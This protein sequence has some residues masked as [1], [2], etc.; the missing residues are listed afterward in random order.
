MKLNKAQMHPRP[1]YETLVKDKILEPKDKIAL[2]DRAATIIR[3]TQQLS[4]YDDA[5]FLDLEKDNG[6]IAKEQAQ[7]NTISAA[8]GIDVGGSIAQTRA[9][10]PGPHQGHTFAPPPPV[11]QP[12]TQGPP[13]TH[14]TLPTPRG[15]P[16]T[17][18]PTSQAATTPIPQQFDIGIDDDMN[19][20]QRETDKIFEEVTR[21]NIRKGKS[22]D[23]QIAR[24]LGPD[25]ETAD[26]SYVAR[27]AAEGNKGR[28][29][30]PRGDATKEIEVQTVKP[31]QKTKP[32]LRE[33]M[34]KLQ[35]GRSAHRKD[36]TIGL[37]PPTGLQ[38]PPVGMEP[39]K[40]KAESRAEA[41]KR[42]PV[43]VPRGDKA[44]KMDSAPIASKL[45]STRAAS[46]RPARSRSRKD[47]QPGPA[48]SSS[49]AAPAT[50]KAKSRSRSIRTKP[51]PRAASEPAAA[52][53]TPKAK[54]RSRSRGDVRKEKE[55][56]LLAITVPTSRGKKGERSPP[57]PEDKRTRVRSKT[58]DA[59]T[60]RRQAAA[61]AANA[62]P[63]APV[64]KDKPKVP[65]V[66]QKPDPAPAKGPTLR[67]KGVELDTNNDEAYWA[68]QG[69]G[70]IHDQL[71]LRGYRAPMKTKFKR[72]KKADLAKLIITVPLPP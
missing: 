45:E 71:A 59:K 27:L 13:R 18:G 63:T 24:H 43:S 8:A 42:R 55:P 19:D 32:S 2:P 1:T 58:P 14:A 34:D 7:Q 61:P 33:T 57:P 66:K 49:S 21:Q 40:P 28:G 22:I 30:Y 10:Q 16:Q 54:S 23:E 67:G 56:A 53:A 6:K 64:K 36:G 51:P 20:A 26:Q 72:M 46:A 62:T 38:P 68:K 52:P 25:S 44:P 60:A 35:R 9:A 5:E 37:P 48:S 50:P 70:Y 31:Q 41:M 17:L 4:R 12:S 39:I 15:R 47:E 65:I 3:K 29:R 69:L 11:P